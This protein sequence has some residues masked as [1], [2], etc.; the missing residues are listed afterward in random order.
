LRALAVALD[1]VITRLA[2][3]ITMFG[4]FTFTTTRNALLH[5]LIIRLHPI[6]RAQ[7]FLLA[8]MADLIADSLTRTFLITRALTRASAGQ[9]SLIT[10]R[11]LGHWTL[12]AMPTIDTKVRTSRINLTNLIGFALSG[13]CRI[14]IKSGVVLANIFF[15]ARI[16]LK[17]IIF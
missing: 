4:P 6:I 3:I 15:N 5:A 14:R 11:W 13:A 2:I 16:T 1:A 12:F 10:L 8:L 7:P 9:L 17:G